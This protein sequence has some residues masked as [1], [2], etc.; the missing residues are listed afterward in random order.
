M[1]AL[2][3]ESTAS[4]NAASRGELHESL[5]F[6]ENV[7]ARADRPHTFLG[8]L[9]VDHPLDEHHQLDRHQA[10]DPEVLEEAILRDVIFL[11]LTQLR[12]LADYFDLALALSATS[13]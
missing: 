12:N 11:Q 3:C 8:K 9:P 13:K 6:A 1:E 4:K 10:V 7:A 5:H 2:P